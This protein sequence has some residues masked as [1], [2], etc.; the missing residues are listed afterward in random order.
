MSLG[1]EFEY[2]K[3][4]ALLTA[5]VLTLGGL[6]IIAMTSENVPRKDFTSYFLIIIPI[7]WTISFLPVII[8]WI[9]NKVKKEK[10]IKGDENG[11]GK[12]SK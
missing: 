3:G 4:K 10:I 6:L 12:F 5:I 1:D 2:T 9:I 8:C 11:R 7:F